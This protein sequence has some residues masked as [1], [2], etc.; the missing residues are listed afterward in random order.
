MDDRLSF[1]DVLDVAGFNAN[2]RTAVVEFCCESLR[3]LARLPSKDLD[4]AISNLHKSLANVTPSRDRVRLNATR[5]ITLHA[6][7]MHCLDRINCDALLTPNDIT[8]LQE[9]NIADMRN[10]YLETTLTDYTTKGLGEVTIP[11]LTSPKWLEFKTALTESLSRIIGKNKIPLSYLV[12]NNPTNDF[13]AQYDNRMQRLVACTLHRGAAFTSDN[14]DLFSLIVQHT[15]GTE[16][17]SLVQSHERRRNGRQAWIAL[18]SHFEG[19]TYRERIA[20]EAGQAIRSALY[21]GPKRN[22]SFGDYYSR[23]SK[24]HIKLLRAGKPM[25][26]EQQ[27]D[28]FVQGIQCSV[29]QSIVVNLAG[30][31][32]VRTS[33]DTYYNAVASRLEL[34]LT[35]TGKSN[36]SVTRQVNQVTKVA[37]PSKRKGDNNSSRTSKRA[38]TN[39]KPEAR[40]YSADEW[41]ALTPDQQS[42]VKSLHKILKNSRRSATNSVNTANERAMVPYGSNLTPNY[43]QVYQLQSQ[44]NQSYTSVPQAR[45]D[46]NATNGRILNQVIRHNQWTPPT[47]TIAVPPTPQTRGSTNSTGSLTAESGEVGNAWGVNPY[48]RN[49]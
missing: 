4:S 23:H 18:T 39:F 6:L 31:Q 19:A 7:R 13:A 37:N 11:K 30:D 47:P 46:Q 21:T 15:E 20:Q 49:Y 45:Y 32:T 28:A 14:G 10:E 42:Q 35:L 16:G 5:C 17:Y 26:I 48:G 33:F 44:D 1:V 12:R 22:F 38:N 24:A 43:R 41:K 2:A 40:R 34:A 29:T 9:G 25:S 3:E 8:N 27:I 36:T